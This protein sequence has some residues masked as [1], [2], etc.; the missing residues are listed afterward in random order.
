LRKVSPNS[1]P[2]QVVYDL[3]EKSKIFVE[4]GE[5]FVK[6]G[7]TRGSVFVLLEGPLRL[8]LQVRS[9]APFALGKPARRAVEIQREPVKGKR[10]SAS[11]KKVAP[12]TKKF[13]CIQF[14]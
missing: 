14:G 6:G 8:R 12:L 13:F 5:V 4:R 9:F 11:E 1:N 3:T 10:I 7:L 2:N